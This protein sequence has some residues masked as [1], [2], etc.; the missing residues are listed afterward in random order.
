MDSGPR[1]I[2]VDPAGKFAYVPNLASDEVEVFSIGTTGALNIAS[3]VRTR[4]QA[5]AIA[6]SM[7]TTAVTYTP[8]FTS[9][10]LSLMMFRVL[11]LMSRVVLSPRL[12]ARHS[13][14][15]PDRLERW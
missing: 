2:E 5:V 9:Q 10:I 14:L 7:G 12:L 15:A 1:S 6:L 13:R 8:K 4:P 11:R 3:R